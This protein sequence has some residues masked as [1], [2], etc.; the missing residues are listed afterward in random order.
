MPTPQRSVYWAHSAND[1]GRGTRELLADHLR[2]V[3]ECAAMFAEPFNAKTQA[4]TAGLLHD[5]GKY[6]ERFQ[7][8]LEE[9]STRAGDHWSAGALVLAKY[10]GQRGVFPALGVLGHHGELPLQAWESKAIANEIAKAVKAHPED[11][12]GTD[13]AQML[14]LF[15]ADGLP[16][17]AIEDGFRRTEHTAAD[18]LDVRMLFSALVDADFLETEAHFAGNAAQPR[19]PRPPGPSLDINAALRGFEQHL[20]HVR[21]E[22]AHDPMNP[23]RQQL[24]E[25]CLAAAEWPQG[26]FS[27]S[28]PTGSGKTLAMLAFA[29]HHAKTHRLRRIILVMPFLNIIDQTAQIYRQI[30]SPDAGFHPLTV[31][32]HHSLADYGGSPETTEDT[33]QDL[34]RLLT[35]NW[36]APIILTT[37]V[38][39]FESLFAARPGRCRKLHRL[40]QSVILFDEVQTLPANLA[41]ATLAAL[42]RLT[43]QDGPY[44]SSVVFATATQ[45]AFDHLHQRVL[46]F[47]PVGWQP[48]EIIGNPQPLYQAAAGRVQIQ[49]RYQSPAPLTEIASELSELPQ[50]LCVVNMKR[51]ALELLG[52]LKRTGCSDLLHLSTSMCPVHREE[53]LA[54]IRHRL[55]RGQP[56][57]LVATQCVE[58]GVDLDFPVVYRA[59][60]PLEAIAQAAGR[61]NRH[62][63]LGTGRV[64]VFKPK[65]DPARLYPPGYKQ[66]SSVTEM[67]LNSLASQGTLERIEIINDPQRL[68]QYFTSLYALAG[69]LSTD[70]VRE[71]EAELLKAIQAG[72][73]PRVAELYR[74]IKQDAINILVPYKPEEYERLLSELRDQ[75]R[76]AR[77]YIRG[78]T[79]RAARHAVSILRPRAESGVQNVL[80]QLTD[81][82]GRAIPDWYRLRQEELYVE[83]TGFTPPSE[84]D[85]WML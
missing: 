57:R 52:E 73:F 55:A 62:G 5:L 68:R 19:A 18:M 1:D 71:D 20:D 47:A 7:K 32:E 50:A 66:P 24:Y 72:D 74:L 8:R 31:L 82:K 30:F 54:E 48:R 60:G 63:S 40:A 70:S 27:L 39:F 11:Y 46:E 2:G 77:G 37:T 65:D 85:L 79:R 3:A 80:E 59:L 12:S 22:H 41:V 64:V 13:I 61:C 36:D 21:R 15:K 29:L 81:A 83:Q 44:R 38:Q 56:L 75:T 78:W 53:T 10:F 16:Q 9:P 58:A 51:H 34:G 67:F 69:R 42:S 28:A 23:V 35:E 76:L 26:A 45:P 84:A 49:W 43:E 25:A 14:E 4:Y 17:P 33:G 6:T